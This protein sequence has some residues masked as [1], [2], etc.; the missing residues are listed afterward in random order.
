MGYMAIIFYFRKIFV[1]FDKHKGSFR[2]KKLT[3]PQNLTPLY[4]KTLEKCCLNLIII[5]LF[6]LFVETTLINNQPF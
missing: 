2:V 4:F 1:L 6:L 3:K 5:M